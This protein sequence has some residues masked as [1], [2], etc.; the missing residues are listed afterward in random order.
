MESSDPV[1]FVVLVTVFACS[2]F[3]HNAP[4]PASEQAIDAQRGVLDKLMF[5]VVGAGVGPPTSG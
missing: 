5:D 1:A 3:G 2:S 4:S